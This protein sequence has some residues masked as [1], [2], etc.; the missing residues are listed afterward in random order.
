M[1][2]PLPTF[3]PFGSSIARGDVSVRPWEALAKLVG[4]SVDGYK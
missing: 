4:V 1:S 3:R 2:T